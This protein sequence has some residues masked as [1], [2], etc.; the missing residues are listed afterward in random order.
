MYRYCIGASKHLH[1]IDRLNGVLKTTTR[2]VLT[3]QDLSSDP[4]VGSSQICW[5]NK[6]LEN[7][8]RCQFENLFSVAVRVGLCVP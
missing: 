2:G 3:L 7:G 1:N 4:L 6:V 8:L 5:L